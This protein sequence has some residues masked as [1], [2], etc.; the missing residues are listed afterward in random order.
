MSPGSDT[1]VRLRAVTK[2]YGPVT[3]VAGLDLEV[4]RAQVLALLGP[5]GAGK[6]TTVEMCEG[7]SRPDAGSVRV[8][9]LD[10]V[11]DNAA[12]RARTGVMFQ[13]GLPLMYQGECVGAIG[14][15]GVQSHED[16]QIAKAGVDTLA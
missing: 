9:G 7:F 6:T 13:G 3:A 14:V 4:E 15:S 1:V 5:N 16:E 12:V 10:P 11:A 8:L 2:R